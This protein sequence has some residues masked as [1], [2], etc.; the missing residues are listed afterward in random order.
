MAQLVF[1][2]LIRWIVIYPVDSVIQRLNNQ[3]LRTLID[4][5]T[6]SEQ[7]YPVTHRGSQITMLDACAYRFN[8]IREFCF[9]VLV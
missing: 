5:V 7:T 4:L 9:I 2:I 8:K 1:L 6:Y 3:A